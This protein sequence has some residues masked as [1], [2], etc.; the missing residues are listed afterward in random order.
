MDHATKR[1]I[2]K[3]SRGVMSRNGNPTAAQPKVTHDP[4]QQVLCD[5]CGG[6]HLRPRIHVFRQ[7]G[8]VIGTVDV[9]MDQ[10]FVCEQCNEPVNIATAKLRREVQKFESKPA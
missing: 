1:E 3:E 9:T 8:Q 4:Q 2:Q 5:N 10:L 6:E 7:H